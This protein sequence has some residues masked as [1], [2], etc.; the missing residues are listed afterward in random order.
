MATGDGGI[1]EGAIPEVG[2]ERQLGGDAAEESYVEEMMD[3]VVVAALSD[4]VISAEGKSA[5][6]G[7]IDRGEEVLGYGD[8]IA[9]LGEVSGVP[10]SDGSN[11][12]LSEDDAAISDAEEES[13]GVGTYVEIHGADVQGL[14]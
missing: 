12:G 10:L 3:V 2:R 13:A 1:R 5:D 6:G 14:R 11:P 8:D 7:R 9:R 4:E